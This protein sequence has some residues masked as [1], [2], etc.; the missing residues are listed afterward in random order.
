MRAE[1]PAGPRTAGQGAAGHHL[2]SS[3]EPGGEHA[4]AVLRV[5][6]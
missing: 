6:K 2:F 5:G 4:E 1:K 3:L